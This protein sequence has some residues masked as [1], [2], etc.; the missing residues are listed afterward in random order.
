MLIITLA[1]YAPLDINPVFPGLGE[2]VIT[3]IVVVVDIVIVIII[4]TIIIIS[5]LLFNI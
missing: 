4:F 2:I 5:S 1:D 3:I